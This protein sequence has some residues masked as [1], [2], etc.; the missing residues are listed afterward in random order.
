MFDFKPPWRP[1]FHNPEAFYFG[2]VAGFVAVILI[3]ILID[4]LGTYL[5]ARGYAKPFFIRGHRIHHVW[6][7]LIIPAGYLSFATLLLMGYVLPIWSGLYMRLLSVLL[8]AGA[9]MLIDF[10]GDRLWPKIRKD[11][12]LHHEWVYAVIFLYILQ[13]VVEV[14]I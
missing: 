13:F 8:V 7:Y 6:I 11:V 9:C 1:V 2:M 12:I 4:Q 10:V 5:F 3:T 14:R